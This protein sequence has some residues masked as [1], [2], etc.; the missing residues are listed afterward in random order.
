MCACGVGPPTRIE[1]NL[2][3]YQPMIN[4]TLIALLDERAG[5]ARFWITYLPK[6]LGGGTFYL[7][8]LHTKDGK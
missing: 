3:P 5:G 1:P 4:K 2:S 8:G 6:S 7:T